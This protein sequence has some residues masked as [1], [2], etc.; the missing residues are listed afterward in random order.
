MLRLHKLEKVM[1][2]QQHHQH[3]KFRRAY[4]FCL[5]YSKFSLCTIYASMR[6]DGGAQSMVHRYRHTLEGP[7][8]VVRFIFGPVTGKI[9]FLP[10][11]IL[12]LQL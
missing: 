12:Q 9:V 6:F 3:D 5:F 7:A 2:L 11:F 1:M 4:G 8:E 10:I